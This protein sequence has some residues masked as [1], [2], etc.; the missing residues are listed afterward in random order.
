MDSTKRLR[1]TKT[2][3]AMP[4]S[5]LLEMLHE[6][7]K[8]FETGI[9]Q[10]IVEEAKRRNLVMPEQEQ[11]PQETK[12]VKS[13]S[14]GITCPQCGCP[15]TIENSTCESCGTFFNRSGFD[16]LS[17]A[18]TQGQIY[19]KLTKPDRKNNPLRIIGRIIIASI[20]L[21]SGIA[22]LLLGITSMKDA[23]DTEG[24]VVAFLFTC[25][26]GIFCMVLG[27]MIFKPIFGR[28]KQL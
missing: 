11:K 20:L 24:S 3:A 22:H 14:Q 8:N 25:I 6:N 15:N 4:D 19:G 28:K 13:A 9:F 27:A 5:Q 17:I 21:L 18:R 12:E 26:V 10:I 7:K 23:I 2:Y 1:L 16:P